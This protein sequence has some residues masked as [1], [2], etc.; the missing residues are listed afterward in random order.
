MYLELIIL[1]ALGAFIIVFVSTAFLEK[2]RLH[3]FVPVSADEPTT[4]SSYFNAM[5]VAAARLGFRPAGVFV[6]KRASVLYQAR[7]AVW[8]SSDQNILLLVGGG[9]TARVP[10]K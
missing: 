8:V 9:K 2:Q 5:N 1:A 3:D 6:Q 4:D 7:M 10:I